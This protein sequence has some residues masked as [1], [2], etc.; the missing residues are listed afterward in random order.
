MFAQIVFRLWVL[1]SRGH[2]PR[3]VVYLVRHLLFPDRIVVTLSTGAIFG[4]G[5][6]GAYLEDVTKITKLKNSPAAAK[7]GKMVVNTEWGAFNNSVSSFLY[8]PSLLVLKNRAS[9]RHFRQQPST[10]N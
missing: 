6:N 10:T 9:E 3:E 5:T 2:I 4:T 1:F 8:P 7:G